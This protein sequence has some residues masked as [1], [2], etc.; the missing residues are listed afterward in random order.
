MEFNN[1]TTNLDHQ[2]LMVFSSTSS[3]SASTTNLDHQFLMV[4]SST[5]S[6]SASTTNL[7]DHYRGQIWLKV[8][9]ANIQ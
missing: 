1:F 8:D 2:F 7:D 4:F 9:K 3:F 6:F 5:S